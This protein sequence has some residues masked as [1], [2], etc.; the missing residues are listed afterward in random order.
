YGKTTN[1][2]ISRTIILRSPVYE[3]FSS[4][5]VGQARLKIIKLDCTNQPML[6]TLRDAREQTEPTLTPPKANYC[7]R[8][9]P[10]Q[11]ACIPLRS[12]RVCCRCRATIKPA[13]PAVG[14]A[15]R[16]CR[17]FLR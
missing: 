4:A 8:R 10:R 11:S 14:V 13:Q 2:V 5:C 6:L 16:T 15:L 1:K 7:T 12:G 3:A 17:L 9:S